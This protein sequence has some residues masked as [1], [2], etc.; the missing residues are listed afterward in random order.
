MRF[1]YRLSILAAVP[2]LAWSQ[3]GGRN[4]AAAQQA[5]PQ[6]PAAQQTPA[7]GRGGRGGGGAEATGATD[8]YNYDT[9]AAGAQPIPDSPP[10]E[11]HQKITAG[12]QSLAYTAQAGY[13]PLRNA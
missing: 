3:G 8:F 4:R 1:V 6:A 2:I 10:V 11:T 5:A 12:G 7:P 9:S 13:L